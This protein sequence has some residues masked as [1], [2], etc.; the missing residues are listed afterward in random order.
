M[1][2]NRFVTRYASATRDQA[3]IEQL[4]PVLAV[5]N[6]TVFNHL[7]S[8]LL[9]RDIVEPTK[10]IAAQIAAWELLWGTNDQ[11]GILAGLGEAEREAAQRVLE[12]AHAR[13]T[14][15]SALSQ[16][17]A[18]DLPMDLRAQLRALVTRL[19]TEP[20]F[21]LD[22]QLITATEPDPG[23]ASAL[24]GNLESL[25]RR[26]TDSEIA[27][28][29]VAPLGCT[30]RD[31]QWGTEEVM[32]A[33]SAAGRPYKYRSETL[34]VHHAVDGLDHEAVRS[35]LERFMIATGLVDKPKN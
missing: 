18:Y 3:F 11:P 32:R 30:H 34:I 5:H 14:T 27:D 16:T 23:Q 31:V 1:A 19:I 6:A 21:S 13:S 8:Q 9:C 29:V 12:E 4:G 17:V 20:T 35:A 2:F 25:T 22:A 26:L 33:D 7:L 28:Y 24:L 10:T 15:L